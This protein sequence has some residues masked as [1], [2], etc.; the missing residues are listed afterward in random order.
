MIQKLCHFFKVRQLKVMVFRNYYILKFS[1][2]KVKML[3]TSIAKNITQ[4]ISGT[5]FGRDITQIGIYPSKVIGKCRK[6]QY[7]KAFSGTGSELGKTRLKIDIRNKIILLYNA[8]KRKSQQ[9]SSKDNELIRKISLSLIVLHNNS[10]L[11][12]SVS[13][14]IRCE[15]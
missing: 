10:N 13:V 14:S 6:I 2:I 12:C 7:Y 3:V 8:L 11:T 5:R 1:A 4:K 15:I 9:P